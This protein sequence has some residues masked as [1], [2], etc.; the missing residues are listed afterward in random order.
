MNTTNRLDQ[1]NL[2]RQWTVVVIYEI[3]FDAPN[4]SEDNIKE[5]F[6]FNFKDELK[7]RKVEESD[8][9]IYEIKAKDSRIVLK[10][11]GEN[12]KSLKTFE[13][14]VK[15]KKPVKEAIEVFSVVWEFD[16]LGFKGSV[17]DKKKAT[18]MEFKKI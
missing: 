8:D 4:C 6:D 17:R 10:K 1:S 14:T 3:K 5:C 7:T 18:L 16:N 2:S 15:N 12:F 9:S 13:V 11:A